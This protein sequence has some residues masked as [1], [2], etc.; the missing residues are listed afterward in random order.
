[1]LSDLVGRLAVDA[2]EELRRAAGEKLKSVGEDFRQ[3][4]DKLRIV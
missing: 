1:M 4:L 3:V 2:K